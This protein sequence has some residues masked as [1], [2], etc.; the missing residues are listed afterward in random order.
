MWVRPESVRPVTRSGTSAV[1]AF[2]HNVSGVQ[3]RAKPFGSVDRRCGQFERTADRTNR[4]RFTRSL[5]NKLYISFPEGH[6]FIIYTRLKWKPHPLFLRS[7]LLS[8]VYGRNCLDPF[9]FPSRQAGFSLRY[10]YTPIRSSRAVVVYRRLT[11]LLPN[12]L[13]FFWHR[14]K[15][16]HSAPWARSSWQ[17]G[18]RRLCRQKAVLTSISSRPTTIPPQPHPLPYLP[19]PPTLTILKCCTYL[20]SPLTLLR[21]SSV[22]SGKWMTVETHE[23]RRSGTRTSS[24]AD[25]DLSL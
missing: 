15:T 14:Q 21:S 24:T 2:L 19:P 20:H 13:F 1:L 16:K 3:Q 5:R 8:E 4:M 25:V 23:Y 17:K 22:F 6:V 9:W 18:R 11:P 12:F 7:I 10:S